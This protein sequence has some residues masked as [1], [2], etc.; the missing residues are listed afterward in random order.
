MTQGFKQMLDSS[1][2]EVSAFAKDLIANQLMT[3]GFQ[4]GRG[5]YIDM[6]PAGVFTTS[7][8]NPA[9]ESPVQFFS[10]IQNNSH[11]ALFFNDFVHDFIRNFGTSRVRW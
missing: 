9:L 6:I 2:P 4:P 8:L 11:D 1:D 7:M 3:K 5:T 10:R